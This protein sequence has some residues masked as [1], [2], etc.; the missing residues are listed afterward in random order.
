MIIGRVVSQ[1]FATQKNAK[2][3]GAK[4]LLVQPLDLDGNEKGEIVLAVDAGD[5]GI[6][7]RV[8][9]VQEGWS[10]NYV[11]GA[12]EAPIDA[13]VVGVVDRVDLS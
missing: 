13:A 7:E 11:F 6:N 5:A 1:L 9:V 4:L 10:A 12:V 2:L 3:T 8:L